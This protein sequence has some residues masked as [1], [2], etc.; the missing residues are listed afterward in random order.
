MSSLSKFTFLF[1][2]MMWSVWACE[3]ETSTRK[4]ETVSKPITAQK[5]RGETPMVKISG[6][7]IEGRETK[8]FW[9]DKHPVTVAEFA[10]FVKA[11]GHV[12][13]AE[14]FGDAGVFNFEKGSWDLVKGANWRMPQGPEGAKAAE[15]H[16]VTQ[17][18]WYDAQA[19]A[20]WAGKRLPRQDEWELAARTN[21]QEKLR[22]PWGNSTK[23]NGKFMANYW[24]G[25][26]PN[27][28]LAEDGYLTTSPVG[29]FGESSVGLE[30]I[31][32]NVWEWMEDWSPVE[33][34]N[35]GPE[36]IARGGSF[37]CDLNVCHGF[38]IIGET[39]STPETSL[40]HTG[41]RCV[42]DI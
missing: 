42:R 26:F 30:D 37:L 27:F 23:V 40:F 39:S 8:D 2:L 35:T 20:K 28:N 1:I 34:S 5:P 15:D 24:Q 18:S 4:T 29:H 41:F 33:R 9:M 31:V 36:K 21:N 7:S 13:S 16:P 22:Y 3:T 12:S 25:A 6:G 17:V 32:G 11:T 38:Q 10:V 14:K 19:Y